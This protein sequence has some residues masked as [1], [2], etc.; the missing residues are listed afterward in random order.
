MGVA[1]KGVEE[2]GICVVYDVDD[3]RRLGLAHGSLA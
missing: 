3:I 2:E 1:D